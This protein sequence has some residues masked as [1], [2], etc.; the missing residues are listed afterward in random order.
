[1]PVRAL[2]PYGVTPPAQARRVIGEVCSGVAGWKESFS[3]AGVSSR[4][5][6]YLARFIDRDW[7]LDQR[8]SFGVTPA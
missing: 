2:A 4:D 6:D 1:M 3:A 8:R 7:L 5:I